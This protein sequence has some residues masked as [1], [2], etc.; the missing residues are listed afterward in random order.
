MSED[1]N[2]YSTAFD[3]AAKCVHHN[4]HG[5]DISLTKK[6]LSLH[7]VQTLELT[8]KKCSSLPYNVQL[9]VGT[10]LV[11]H[12]HSSAKYQRNI[13]TFTPICCVCISILLH[14]FPVLVSIPYVVH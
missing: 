7:K 13:H 12:W 2:S 5:L 14:Q 11:A 3:A 4:A 10:M 9:I 1:S 6:E 8:R